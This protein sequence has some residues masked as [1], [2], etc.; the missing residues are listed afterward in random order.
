MLIIKSASYASLHSKSAIVYYG[1]DIPYTMLGIH[2]YIILEPDNVNVHTTGFK[3]FQENIYAYVSINEILKTRTYAKNINESWKISKNSVWGSDILDI[4]NIQY[5]DFLLNQII[6]KLHTKGF[7]NFFF[8]TLDSYQLLSLSNDNKEQFRKSLIHFIKRFKQKF[9]QAKLITNRG[10][11]LIDEIHSFVDAVLFESYYYGMNSSAMTYIQVSQEDRDWLDIQL[12]KIEK[13]KIPIIALDYIPYTEKNKRDENIIA[14]K[15]RGF[16]PYISNIELNE[17]GQSSKNAFKREILILYNGKKLEDNLVNISYAHI[18]ASTPLEYMGYI[19]VLK[20]INT[21]LPYGDLSSRYAGVIV[22]MEHQLNDYNR[23]MKWT[24]YVISQ[25]VKLLFLGDESLALDHTLT[26]KLGLSITKNLTKKQT[27]N[28]ITNQDEMIGYEVQPS[29]KFHEN[30]IDIKNENSLLQYQNEKSQHSTLAAIMPWGGF[31]LDDTLMA[32]FGD[33]NLWIV[34]PFKLF[35]KALSLSQIPIPDPTT[36]NGRRLMFLHVDGD[37]SMNR[38]ENNPEQFSIELILSDFLIPYTF[39]Q[40]IS[41]I[42]SETAPYGSYPKLSKQL[43]NAA[44]KIFKL[45]HVEGATHTY[46]HPYKWRKIEEDPT[47]PKYAIPLKEY[48][49]SAQREI[50]DSLEYINKNL[51]PKNRERAKTVFWT[52]DCYPSKNVLDYVYSHDIINING[53]DTIITNDRPWLSL[54]QPFS[55][56][57]GDYYQVYTGQQNENVYTNDWLG[58]FWGFKKVIQTFQ[59]TNQPRRFKPINVYYHF[60]SASK[61]ASYIALKNIYDW[62]SKQ[63][64]MHIFTSEYP[65]KVTNFYDASLANDDN[66]WLL[67]GFD[68]LRTIRIPESFGYPIIEESEG[69]IGYKNNN[70]DFYV[71]LDAKKE[72]LLVLGKEELNQNILVEANARLISKDQNKLHFKGYMPIS[73]SFKVKKECN[74]ISTPQAD[75]IRHKNSIVTLKYKNAKDVYVTQKCS[76]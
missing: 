66:I 1:K 57:S 52:G 46:G 21:P 26:Q 25:D 33:D 76:K 69:V 4:T 8:D 3:T 51:I 10:F 12:N 11:E 24:D 72:K 15:K 75:K 48:T 63:K 42:E 23:L 53:G 2:D 20:D 17:I 35:E 70:K 55:I 31:V 43:E 38:V 68:S 30:M 18:F 67:K 16:I 58:P 27:K 39:P 40:S 71:H 64:V 34:D 44:R 60:Y 14:L 73:L 9:P 13:Y 74:L 47:N 28:S 56:K 45:P 49:F 29:I 19:P 50:G 62:V 22:W 61:R 6:G 36:E 37:A 54:I 5:Q 32:N 7:K 41:I 59:L 65:S